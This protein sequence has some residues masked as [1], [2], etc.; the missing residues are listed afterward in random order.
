M[1]SIKTLALR[2]ENHFLM[3]NAGVKEEGSHLMEVLG[4][5]IIAAVLLG[6]AITFFMGV[7]N[8]N[9]DK[10]SDAISDLFTTPTSTP[11]PTP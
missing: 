3:R 7:W 4:T 1:K 5:L 8:D 6:L 9:S 2:A 11:T 10:A